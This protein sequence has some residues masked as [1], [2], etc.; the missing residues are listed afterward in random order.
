MWLEHLLPDAQLVTEQSSP[1]WYMV[2]LARD[3][4]FPE[5][6]RYEDW[7]RV[8]VVRKIREGIEPVELEQEQSVQDVDEFAGQEGD[9]TSEGL[10]VRYV[11]GQVVMP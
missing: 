9:C 1:S 8:V 5:L 11:N 4:S 3:R 7:L 6:H 2:G 10:V